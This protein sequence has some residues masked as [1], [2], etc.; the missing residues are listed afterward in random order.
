MQPFC[1]KI[2]HEYTGYDVF[3]GKRTEKNSKSRSPGLCRV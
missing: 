3:K 1:L 2:D